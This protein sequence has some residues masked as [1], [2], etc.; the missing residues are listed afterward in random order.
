MNEQADELVSSTGGANQ[1]LIDG[2]LYSLEN[3][4]KL[5]DQTA[6]S[7][8]EDLRKASRE[9]KQYQAEVV[10]L[11]KRLSDTQKLVLAPSSTQSIDQLITNYQV[12]EM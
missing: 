2:C 1:D 11:Q 12:K 3:H 8:A 6:E 4:I 5:L 10:D 7:Q 9:W